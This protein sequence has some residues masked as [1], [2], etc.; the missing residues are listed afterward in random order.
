METD[1]TPPGLQLQKL[2]KL[3]LVKVFSQTTSIL[4]YRVSV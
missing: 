4:A 1:T 3:E 2:L